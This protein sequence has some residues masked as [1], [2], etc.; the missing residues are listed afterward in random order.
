MSDGWWVVCSKGGRL[1]NFKFDY[2]LKCD[3]DTFVDIEKVAEELEKFNDPSIYWGFFAGRA[4]VQNKGKRADPTIYYYFL[5]PIN[6]ISVIQIHITSYVTN[7]YRM[8]GWG[9]YTGERTWHIT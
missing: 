9:I 5:T 6:L 7:T 4:P 8:S 3:A 1:G 2:L